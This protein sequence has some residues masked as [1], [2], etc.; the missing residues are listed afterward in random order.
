[1]LKLGPGELKSGGHRRDSILADAVEAIIGAVYLDGGMEQSK[2]L[3]LNWFQQRLANITLE[4]TNKDN[5]TRLQE[6]LQARKL[7]L[8]E[9]EIVDVSGKSHAQHFVVSCKIDGLSLSASAEG[10]SRRQAEQIAA[11]K[12]LA[13]LEGNDH[14]G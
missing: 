9:Y 7:E 14:G 12:I 4:D 2:Q 13:E 8:P 6:L 5:K 10:Q 11:G 3:I 1:A